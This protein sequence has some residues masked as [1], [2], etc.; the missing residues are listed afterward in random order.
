MIRGGDS[1]D[2]SVESEPLILEVLLGYDTTNEGPELV[3]KLEP[4]KAQQNRTNVFLIGAIED[5]E[6]DQCFLKE[7]SLSIDEQFE[8]VVFFN[9][10]D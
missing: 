10:T 3:K 5:K 8:W 9:N 6:G 2:T 4:I 1:D 7:W